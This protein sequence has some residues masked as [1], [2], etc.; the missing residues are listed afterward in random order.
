VLDINRFRDAYRRSVQDVMR[1]VTPERQAVIA[2]HNPAL[3]PGRFDLGVYL[4]ASER[5]YA[6]LIRLLNAHARFDREELRTLEVGGFLGAYPLALARLNIPVTLVEHYGYYH[7]AFDELAEYLASA[8]VAIWDADFTQVLRAAPERHTLVTNMAM[9]EHLA[10]SPKILMDNLAS[11]TDERGALVIEVPNIAYF[12]KRRGA[13]MGR[14]VHPDLAAVYESA[15]PFTGHHREYTLQEAI[16]LLSWTGF[17]VD[18]AAL[19]NYSIDLRNGTSL[20]RL[21]TLAVDAWPTMLFPRCREVIMIIAR[22]SR[23]IDRH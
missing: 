9:L 5:R 8:G 20:E 11:A 4:R 6:E 2:T 7:G 18:E 1:F 15:I 12:P 22:L 10:D 13:L 21:R 3:R 19:L 23:R 17:A 14:S 16:D